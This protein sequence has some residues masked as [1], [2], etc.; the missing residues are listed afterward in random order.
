MYKCQIKEKGKRYSEEKETCFEICFVKSCV[1][2]C[3][4][5]DPMICCMVIKK[6]LAL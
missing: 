5:L 3:V 6:N 4:C 1:M 2:A